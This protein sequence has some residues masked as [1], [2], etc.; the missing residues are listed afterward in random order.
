MFKNMN[1]LATPSFET[2]IFLGRHPRNSYYVRELAKLLSISTGS[3]SAQLRNLQENGLI[4]SE[5]KGRTLLFRASMANPIV[6][7]AKIFASLLE[8][9]DLMSAGHD[10]VVR[11]ILF[12][13]CA[14]G[15]DSE[16]SDI[17]LYIETIDRQ[18]VKELLARLESGISRKISPIIVAPDESLQLR[19]RDR[20][21]FERIQAGKI[22]VGEPL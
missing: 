3:A 19:N 4:T 2:L 18:V 16:E 7:E 8:L 11:M 6:R 1:V 12:G 10:H 21:L 14:S 22:L 5:Q 17:D 13:S 9:S 15:E 20:P